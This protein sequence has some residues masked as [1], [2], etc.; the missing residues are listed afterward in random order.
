MTD[1]NNNQPMTDGELNEILRL[2][3]EKLS[4][5][6]EAGE[7]PFKITKYDVT[8]HSSDIKDNFDELDGKEVSVAGRMMSK[9]IMGKASFCHVQDLKG[10]IQCY[11]P[12]EILADYKKMIESVFGE[13]SC[14]VLNIRPVGGYE[15][16]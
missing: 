15:I 1:I 5:L 3:R 2:R 9:R 6:V 13:N 14:C 4:A 12:T 11:I 7:D 16:K 8:H 10:T